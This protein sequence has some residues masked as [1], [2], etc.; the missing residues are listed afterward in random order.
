MNQLKLYLIFFKG[1][2][3]NKLDSSVPPMASST[4]P[5]NA[6]FDGAGYYYLPWNETKP[7]CV[8]ESHWED[9]HFRLDPLN[10]ILKTAEKLVMYSAYLFIPFT[11][12]LSSLP[13]SFEIDRSSSKQ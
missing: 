1:N 4:P 10:I 12:L 11:F 9:I 8:V 5:T 13:A 6:V 7:C 2:Y 3:G